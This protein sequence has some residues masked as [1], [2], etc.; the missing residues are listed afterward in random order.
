MANSS[1]TAS[2]VITHWRDIPAQVTAS[3][4]GGR[5]AERV[6]REL[7]PRFAQAIDMAAMQAGATGTDAYLADWRQGTPTPCGED[8][9]AALL[10]ELA[11]LER[12]YDDERLRALIAGGGR[13]RA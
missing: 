11:R 1:Q 6:K 10:A 8:L 2:L 5:R 4:P 7:S 3:R 12:D 13:E 9:E